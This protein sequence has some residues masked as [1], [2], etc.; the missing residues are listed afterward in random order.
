[1]L[2]NAR[3]QH[4]KLVEGLAKDLGITLQFLPSYSPNL[5][6]MERL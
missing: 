5:D 4:C 3:Y 1:M 2:D 6:W